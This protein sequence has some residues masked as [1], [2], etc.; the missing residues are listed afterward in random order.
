MVKKSLDIAE[1]LHYLEEY[2]NIKVDY[3]SAERLLSEVG[4]INVISPYKHYYH[5]GKEQGKHV[6]PVETELSCYIERYEA[7]K[8]A[9]M[10][11]R[12]NLFEYEK[13]IKT[14]I[15]IALTEKYDECENT[16]DIK[17]KIIRDLQIV[18]RRVENSQ[19]NQKSER[20]LEYL[21]KL[22]D[23]FD[24]EYEY[25]LILNQLQFGELKTFADIIPNRY[26]TDELRYF[27]KNGDTL[28]IIR[29]NISHSSFIEIY[30]NKLNK[31]LFKKNIRAL[32]RI[33]TKLLFCECV[34]YNHLYNS[35][36]KFQKNK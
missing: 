14:Q 18:I 36:N 2:K 10:I 24:V 15:V 5:V 34:N 33:E 13:L 35:Y 3:A 17:S 7:D 1:Q 26:Q 31:Q 25:Y 27:F 12:E 20:K 21:I 22:K 4:Y 6:Y 30:L 19:Q 9:T 32:I 8:K 23:K 16:A 11:I 29:N 28:R